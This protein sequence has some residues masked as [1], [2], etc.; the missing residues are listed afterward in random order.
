MHRRAT[1]QTGFSLIELLVTALI[2]GI[3]LLGLAAL[4]VSTMRSNSGGRNRVTASALAEGCLSAIQ[5]EGSLTWS[6]SAGV[7]GSSTVFVGTRTFTQSGTANGTY[8]IFDINGQPLPPGDPNQVFSVGWVRR[9]TTA[10]TPSAPITNMNMNE[11][12]VTVTW[13]D[14][15]KAAD[16]VTNLASSTLSVSRLIRY[17]V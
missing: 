6:Y 15:E 4:Q 14:Q 8:G 10:A 9:P 11:F 13:K 17:G 7:M 2:F 1:H 16:G 5:A 12:V 3:G